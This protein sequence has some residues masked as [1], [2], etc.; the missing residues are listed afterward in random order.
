[1]LSVSLGIGAGFDLG[2]CRIGAGAASVLGLR[3]WVIFGAFFVPV[4]SAGCFFF[5]FHSI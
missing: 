2:T 1:M 4:G 3:T 5:E